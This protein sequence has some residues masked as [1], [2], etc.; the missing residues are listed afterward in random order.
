MNKYNCTD[1]EV[2]IW[3]DH[4]V[5]KENGVKVLDDKHMGKEKMKAVLS[6]KYLGQIIQ[7]NGRNDQNIKDKTDKAVGNVSK[8]TNAL[9]ER[10]YG[11]HAYKAALLMRQAM[12]LGGLL[13]NAETLTHLTESD[14]TKLTMPDTLLHRALLSTSGNP[15]KVF[16][17]LELGIIPVKYVLISKRL[18]FLHYIL[19]E[20]ISSILRKV[21]DTMK[22]DSRKGDFY[23]LVKKDMEDLD[24]AMTEED[25]RE[26]A[27]TKWK[28][29]CQ[30]S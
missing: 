15:S 12:L 27:R 5:Q 26:H 17:C 11:K 30:R 9:S 3:K 29:L 22:C 20:N 10:P 7:N 18:N 6:K 14:I 21:Y 2:D 8:I 28:Y 1:F 23:N 19:S 24:I 16:M 13:S 4:L 25:I